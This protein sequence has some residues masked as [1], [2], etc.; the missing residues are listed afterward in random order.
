MALA[1]HAILNARLLR[2]P[3]TGAA[4]AERVSVL[5]PARDEADH[6]GLTLTDLL[7]CQGVANMEL[8]VLDDGSTDA[9]PAILAS[10]SD[11]RLRVLHGPNTRP[12]E[13][14]LGK[15]WACH[16]LARQANGSVLVF[17]DA[18]VRFAPEAIAAAV[19]ALRAGRFAMVAPAP[20]QVAETWC[21]RLVQPLLAW[22]WLSTMP[23]RWAETSL[24]PALSSANGQF[25][26]CDATAY[27]AAGG[28][29]AVRGQ[30]MED[31]ALMRAVKASGGYAATLDGTQ[32]ARTRMYRDAGEVVDG[33]GK[34]LWSAFGG[35]VG[36]AAVVATLVLG[37]V[38]PAAA[39]VVGPGPRLRAVGACGYAAGVIGRVVTARRMSDR[40]WPDAATHPA[41]ILAF[42]ALNAVSWARHRRG[43]NLWKGRPVTASAAPGDA[44]S[45]D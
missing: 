39:A 44:A 15:P 12:P 31:I 42:A 19:A 29:R 14:W 9:T 21:E 28:H 6:I 20:R 36:S 24:R 40:L 26:V 3:G 30:V 1:G 45:G 23:L 8:L 34:S 13:G 27:W 43:T 5:V 18:D 32:L 17:A 16:R 7:A 25:L 11:A 41:S 4:T 2:T 10:I 22:S 33:Y 37:Y 35:P 38:V